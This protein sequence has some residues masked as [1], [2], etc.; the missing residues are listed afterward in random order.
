MA[1]NGAAFPHLA[2]VLI[3]VETL[4]EPEPGLLGRVEQLIPIWREPVAAWISSGPWDLVSRAFAFHD[5]EVLA[6]RMGKQTD[7]AD[8]AIAG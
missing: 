8:A 2:G 6:H 4:V 3:A 7:R 1:T 5:L